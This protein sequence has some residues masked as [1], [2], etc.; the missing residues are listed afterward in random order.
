M[1]RELTVTAGTVLFAAILPLAAPSWAGDDAT[2]S[3]TPEAAASQRH[4]EGSLWTL[5]RQDPRLSRF[6]SLVTEAKMQD[7]LDGQGPWTL[8]A[9]VDAAFDALPNEVKARLARGDHETAARIVQHHI[10]SARITHDEV[11]NAPSVQALVQQ[12]RP[13][14]SDDGYSINGWK[15]EEVDTPASNGLLNVIDGI[16]LP[17]FID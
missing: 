9:P 16:L 12:L 2:P 14:L 11:P 8:Y 17:H 5:I 4:A 1:K 10:I 7:V 13:R 15:V 6:A 3:A